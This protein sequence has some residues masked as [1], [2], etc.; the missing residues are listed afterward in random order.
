[1]THGIRRQ[2]DDD[3]ANE[4]GPDAQKYAGADFGLTLKRDSRKPAVVV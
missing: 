1:M 2:G 4:G 3:G